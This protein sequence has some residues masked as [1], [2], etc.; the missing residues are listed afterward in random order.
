MDLE[1]QLDD[2][3]VETSYRRYAYPKKILPHAVHALKAE[4]ELLVRFLMQQMH[5]TF[6]RIALMSQIN[7]SRYCGCIVGNRFLFCG[8]YF[9]EAL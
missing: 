2:A 3:I 4:R 1:S 6:Y 9:P 5:I 7:H 8:V